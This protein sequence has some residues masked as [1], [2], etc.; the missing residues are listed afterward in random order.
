MYTNTPPPPSPPSPIIQIL[1]LQPLEILDYVLLPGFADSL[2]A[3]ELFLVVDC[4]TCLRAGESEGYGR[5]VVA[6]LTKTVD[7]DIQG[8]VGISWM[9]EGSI[10]MGSLLYANRRQL[11]WPIEPCQCDAAPGVYQQRL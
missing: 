5:S 11:F 2:E 9:H 7:L 3:I 4:P 8:C 10:K 1:A 6:S